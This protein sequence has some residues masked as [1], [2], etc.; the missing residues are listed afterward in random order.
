[1]DN[2]AIHL[3]NVSK[4]FAL[5]ENKS[6]LDRIK[7]QKIIEK[8][9]KKILALNKITFSVSPGE[10]MA[11]IGSN[12]SGKTT[13]LRVIS[14]IYKPDSGI[15]KINGHL[16]PLLH[17]GTGFHPELVAE[18]NIT[19][20][21]RLLGMSRLEIEKKIDTIIEFAELKKFMGMKLKHYSSGMRLRLAF[22]TALQIDPDIILID[23]ALAVGDLSFKEKSYDAFQTFK[24]KKKT[25]VFSSHNLESIRDFADS[26]VLIHQGK[27]IKIG[28]PNEVI[29]KYKEISKNKQKNDI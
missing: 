4:T 18:D 9:Q 19:M 12:G 1:M 21:G 7:K 3:E 5:N 13:L 22:S 27:M 16:A 29:E 23:E 25:I 15:V 26:V 17:I 11:I 8:E 28:E 6:F 2:F 24:K 14:G 20:Y 10:I